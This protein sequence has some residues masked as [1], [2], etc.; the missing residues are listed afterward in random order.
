MNYFKRLQLQSS[1]NVALLLPTEAV[2][3]S[4]DEIMDNLYKDHVRDEEGIAILIK[5]LASCVAVSS[6]NG[7]ELLTIS[8][9]LS[10][11]IASAIAQ[12]W[13]LKSSREGDR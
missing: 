4:A 1:R 13:N 11:L 12:A 10:M 3:M 2:R 5:L 7:K 6:K 9:D 8:T